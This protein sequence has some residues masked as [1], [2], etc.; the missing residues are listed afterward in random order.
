MRVL[1]IA[2][3][4]ADINAIPEIRDL[5]RMHR[6]AVF[7]GSVHARDLYEYCRTNEVDII[8]IVSHSDNG[9][10]GNSNPIIVLS[11]GETLGP[12][13]LVSMAHSC[14]AKLLFLN[15]C[16]SAVFASYATRRGVGAAI[17]TTRAIKDSSA[18]KA[19][20][21]FYSTLEVMLRHNAVDFHVAFMDAIPDDGTYGWNTSNSDY[22]AYM[23]AP[24]L[25]KIDVL[26]D[27]IDKMKD[28]IWVLV[29]R[30]VNEQRRADLRGIAIALLIVLTASVAGDITI[31]SMFQALS[32]KI[33][34]LAGIY[35]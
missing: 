21:R 1:L 33:Q 30:R 4:M 24:I 18:W 14:N 34:G 23:I 16:N 27:G 10:D 22:Q 9:D 2:P 28:A 6:V 26:A 7:S 32:S 35:P 3:D 8:H 19:P 5:T 29:E 11:E 13:D 20:M 17:Y 12:Q 15:T 31:Y 25:R